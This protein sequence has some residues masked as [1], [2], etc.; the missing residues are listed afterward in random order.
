MLALPVTSNISYGRGETRDGLQLSPAAEGVSRPKNFSQGHSIRSLVTPP[1]CKTFLRTWIIGGGREIS[2]ARGVCSSW[3]HT[4]RAGESGYRG[5]HMLHMHDEEWHN[6]PS[7]ALPSQCI[8]AGPP[9]RL[10]LLPGMSE[11]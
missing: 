2:Q 11:V 4:A 10:I 9:R 8:G 3:A 7:Q 6:D 5:K 1:C